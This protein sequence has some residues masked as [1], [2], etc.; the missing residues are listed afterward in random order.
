[1]EHRTSAE[2]EGFA[3]V[4]R[5]QKLSKKQLLERWALALEKRKGNPPVHPERDRIQTGKGTVGSTARELPADC[6]VRRSGAAVGRSGE[7][8]IR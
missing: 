1:M 8:P 2:I 4:I 5:P 3:A 7:R 6:S